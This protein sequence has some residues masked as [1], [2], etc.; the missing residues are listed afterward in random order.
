LAASIG[1][2]GGVTV[3]LHPRVPVPA[4]AA[5]AASGQA[6]LL[7]T[8]PTLGPVPAGQLKLQWDEVSGTD[9]YRLRIHD[10]TGSPVVDPLPAYGTTW[11]P[12]DDLLP[13]LVDGTYTWT[14]EAVDRSGDVLARSLPAQFDIGR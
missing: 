5:S 2:L 6:P 4:S 11:R 8:H 1:F 7:S 9:G 3:W 10:H 14:V 13:G 12:P